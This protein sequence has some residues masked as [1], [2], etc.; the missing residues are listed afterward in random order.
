MQG[1]I[2]VFPVRDGFGAAQVTEAGVW[3]LGLVLGRAAHPRRPDRGRA[4]AARR[5]PARRDR[6]QHHRNRP[7]PTGSGSDARRCP[8]TGRRSTGAS[9]AGG[10]R[11]PRRSGCDAA[12][13]GGAGT[14]Q[15]RVPGGGHPRPDRG[16]LRRRPG[17]AR[18]RDEPARPDRHRADPGSRR[19]TG[20]LV[21][22]GAV[23]PVLL[24]D[25]VRRRP[26]T[27]RG[28]GHSPGGQRS[29]LARPAAPDRPARHPPDRSSVDLEQ[30][31]RADP[32]AARP[33]LARSA[34]GHPRHPGGRGRGRPLAAPQRGRR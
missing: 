8:P 23:A 18:R 4:A 31:P 33:G 27:D 6:C 15:G 26:W 7:R 17:H 10:R 30:C 29:A 25:L 11:C 19:R 21:G 1:D 13:R 14:G 3:A 12:G 5:R 34:P 32:A 20:A 16:R 24:A 9:R 28:A 22:A 2:A